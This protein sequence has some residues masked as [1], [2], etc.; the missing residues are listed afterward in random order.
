MTN[1]YENTLEKLNAIEALRISFIEDIVNSSN[2][3]SNTNT[4]SNEQQEEQSIFSFNG[5][6]PCFYG[7]VLDGF[8]IVYEY[9]LDEFEIIEL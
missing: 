9:S 6:L 1:T 7:N 5:K 2:D 4:T 8:M 3:S